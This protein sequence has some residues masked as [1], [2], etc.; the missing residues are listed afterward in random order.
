MMQTNAKV[1]TFREEPAA[2]EAIPKFYARDG[3]ALRGVQISDE[4]LASGW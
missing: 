4:L 1:A 2:P 3:F